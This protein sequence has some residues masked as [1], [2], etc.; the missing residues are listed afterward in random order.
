MT[1]GNLNS[2]APRYTLFKKDFSAN[3]IVTG[4]ANGT[5]PSGQM[6]LTLVKPLGAQTLP[7]VTVTATDA[8]ATEGGDPGAFTVRR[9]GATTEVLTV[10]FSVSGTAA[11]GADFISLGTNVTFALGQSNATLTVTP[12]DD[13][14]V[15]GAEAVVVTVSTNAAYTLGAP[16]S[17]TVTISDNDSS[18]G[19]VLIFTNQI[20]ATYGTGPTAR[21]VTLDLYLPASGPGP[22]PV[23]L[24]LPGGGWATQNKN[25]IP[26][27]MTN[28]TA[29]GYAVASA[30]YSS[31]G[32]AKWPAQI[33]DAKAAVRWLRGNA[34]QFNLDPT[35]LAAVGNSS[36]GHI[37]AFL[38]T[39]GGTRKVIVGGVTVDIEGALGTNVNLSSRVQAALPFFPPTDLL[40]MDHYFTPG[41]ANHNAPGSPESG[42]MGAAI[43]TIPEKT[44]TANPMLFVG[45]NAPP[46]FITHGTADALVPFNQSE[47]LNAALVR[48]GNTP[49]F[50]PVFGGGHGPGVLDSPEVILLMTK[51]LDRIFR[52]Q[53]NN[54]RPVASFTTS[55]TNGPAPLTVAFNA[56]ASIDPDGSVTK[57][58][59][60]FGD[61]TGTNVVAPA[62]TYTV[63]GVYPVALAVRD[64]EGAS[65]SLTKF[66]TVQ[67]SGGLPGNAAPTASIT[68]PPPAGT[69]LA[70]PGKI[71]LQ[72]TAADS[73]GTVTNV[74]FFLNGASLLWDTTPPYAAMFNDLAPGHYTAFTRATDAV[75]ATT[76]SA[77]VIFRVLAPVEIEP[78]TSLTNGQFTFTHHRFGEGSVSYALDV[79]T[80]LSTWTPSALT[81]TLVSTNGPVWQ[82][83][84]TEP[85]PV[86][87]AARKFFRVN[88][89][90]VTLP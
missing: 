54:A 6:Y 55:V 25:S 81:A 88:I 89:A 33:W 17:A 77:P 31:S 23:F 51:F 36:G 72:A 64:A 82:S 68:N 63:P 29:L 41:V 73:D 22:Y 10:N 40:V 1:A 76:T 60:S 21:N 49:T 38:G 15:E 53:T 14:L 16:S 19:G 37:A 78:R 62:H 45:S 18:G 65:V 46:F 34:A 4:G 5:P 50:W 83:R 11:G 48:A 27:A 26:S 7:S 32:N 69:L 12:M 56:S 86:T 79:S 39:S 20:F 75:G 90:P 35:R 44:A 70:A 42:L 85:Q 57:Y 8:S 71:H 24:W 61:D 58:Q 84:F 67:P 52:T 9:T 30:N 3:S 59:W 2:N 87:N 66:I 47:L 80:N 74:E 43:Q 13:A 28:L